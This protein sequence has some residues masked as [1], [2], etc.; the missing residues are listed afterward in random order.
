LPTETRVSTSTEVTIRMQGGNLLTHIQKIREEKR[1]GMLTLHLS[2]GN[3]SAIEWRSRGTYREAV[4]EPFGVFS[5]T[6][7]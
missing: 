2:Q 7:R 1:T 5:D 4:G 6:R 3:I